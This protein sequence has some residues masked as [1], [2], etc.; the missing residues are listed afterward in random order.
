MPHLSKGCR[1]VS[2]LIWMDRLVL[3]IWF[4]YLKDQVFLVWLVR[5]PTKFVE[6]FYGVT[7]GYR[8]TQEVYKIRFRPQNL[9]NG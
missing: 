6:L 7:G 8:L 9:S 5:F 4:E 3:G 1:L 2:E